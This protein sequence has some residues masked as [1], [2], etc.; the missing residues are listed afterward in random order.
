MWATRAGTLAYQVQLNN[1]FDGR[2][3]ALGLLWG[4]RTL[5]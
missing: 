5:Q 4:E 1:P 2:R 3:F